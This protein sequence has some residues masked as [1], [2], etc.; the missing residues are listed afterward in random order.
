MKRALAAG[1]Q[2]RLHPSVSDAVS[3][4]PIVPWRLTS[5]CNPLPEGFSKLLELARFVLRASERTGFMA[6]LVAL[7]Q[8]GKGCWWRNSFLSPRSGHPWGAFYIITQVSQWIKV[9]LPTVATGLIKHPHWL[10][11]HL[12]PIS[13]S[14]CWCFLS[15]SNSASR[16]TQ[17]RYPSGKTYFGSVISPPGESCTLRRLIS[18]FR[19]SLMGL[20]DNWFRL[21]R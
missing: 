6:L 16:R 21:V 14:S 12:C 7:N 3:A 17:R 13:S 9:Q 18:Q 10:S 20:D 2:P 8:W 5:T 1:C 4:S 15:S 19:A 11:S